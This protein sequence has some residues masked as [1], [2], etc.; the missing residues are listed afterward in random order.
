MEMACQSP[1]WR[2]YPY[3]SLWLCSNRRL[4]KIKAS[5]KAMVMVV[6]YKRFW[7]RQITLLALTEQTILRT[8]WWCS[9]CSQTLHDGMC[10]APLR[11]ARFCVPRNRQ[12]VRVECNTLPRAVFCCNWRDYRQWYCARFAYS[13]WHRDAICKKFLSTGTQ[14]RGAVQTTSVP[15]RFLWSAWRNR[16]VARIRAALIATLGWKSTK[17]IKM[18]RPAVPPTAPRDRKSR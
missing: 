9:S 1:P 10:K 3:G 16:R 13:G 8:V 7:E 2:Q 17:P 15:E 4:V 18:R 12:A 5:Y 14:F 11:L 6:R